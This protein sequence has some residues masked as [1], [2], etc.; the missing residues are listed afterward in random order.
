MSFDWSEYLDLAEHLSGKGG[1]Y[2]QEAALR[3]ATSRAYYAAFCHARNIAI[4]KL[5]FCGEGSGKDHGLLRE[6]F[7]G[8]RMMDVA[9]KLGMM[10]EWRK[11][12][13]YD[14]NVKRLELIAGSAVL[15]A[16]EVLRAL[17]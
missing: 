7:R 3:S 2:S 16:K 11:Q 13:D 6:Y 9:K 17:R 4:S 1:T 12:C 5:H 14:N 15:H 8:L 10:H